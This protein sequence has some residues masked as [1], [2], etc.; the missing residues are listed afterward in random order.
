MAEDLEDRVA[1]VPRH[2][3]GRPTSPVEP[4][5]RQ[6]SARDLRRA[7]DRDRTMR[8]RRRVAWALVGAVALVTASVVGS[9]WWIERDVA[10]DPEPSANA[11]T[12]GGVSALL[13]LSHDG[14]DVGY[15]L[16]ASH[17]DADDTK[18]LFPRSLV[19]IVPG[20]GTW[21]LGFASGVGEPDLPAL[22]LTNLLGTR[23]DGT[24]R[25]PAA[26]LAAALDGAT[27][28]L[29]SPLMVRD[30]PDLVVAAAAGSAPRNADTI[31]LLLTEQ[32]SDN[33]LSFMVRQGVVWRALLA[34]AADAPEVVAALAEGM[35]GDRDVAEAAL[36][37]L[38]ADPGATVTAA[39]VQPVDTLGSGQ[40]R[41]RLQVGDAEALSS[42][43]MPWLVIA[44]GVRIRVEIL[45][46]TGRVGV[47]APVASTLVRAGH[48]VV[49]TDNADTLDFRETRVVG[50]TVD[51]QASAVTV[52]DDL[53]FGD[54]RIEQRQPSLGVDVTVIVGRDAP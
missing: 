36:A 3:R 25:V 47:T 21:D 53:G 26:A 11:P 51:N 50:H 2:R 19:A 13:L 23:I 42:A 6:P 32:G 45:N 12:E 43:R 27:I 16:V 37:A 54:I 52:R 17:P 24:A 22:T 35:S 40:E 46:G 44:D 30:G 39:P 38:A 33:Q 5:A 18:M 34:A 9:V 8:G 1:D 7:A 4:A 20:Y 31:L 41:Y 14:E 48:R 10:E 15:G 49:R 28:D 29:P